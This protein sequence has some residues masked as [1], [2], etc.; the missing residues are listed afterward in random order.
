MKLLCIDF[1]NFI[2]RH[3]SNPYSPHKDLLGRSVA[4]P[5]GAITQVL[6]LVD[7]HQP[8][9]LLIARDSKRDD[10]FRRELSPAYKEHRT[11]SDEDTKR[12]F[13]LAYQVVELFAWPC[14][15]VPRYEADDVIASA[16]ATFPGR[17]EVVSGDRDLLALCADDTTV[18]LLR[19]GGPEAVDAAGCRR[20]YGV[21]PRQVRDYKAL[22]G[23]KSDGIHGVDG[24]GAKGAV[25]LLT[26]YGSVSALYKHLDGGGDLAGVVSPSVQSKL[27]VGRERARLSWQLAGLVDNLPIDTDALALPPRPTWAEH[28]PALSALGLTALQ[29]PLDG[30]GPKRSSGPLDMDD[31][32]KQL[33]LT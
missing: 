12:Q 2:I 23:D 18:W 30:T 14:V 16:C 21:D 32:F 15:M 10:T 3:A 25:K 27:E 6:R 19:S 33:S 13:A 20:I 1:S 24:I 26:A 17:C 4:G 28:D 11:E 9:H 31:V 22:V 7:Q 5:V 8:S 29:K